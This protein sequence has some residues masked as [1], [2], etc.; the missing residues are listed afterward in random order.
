MFWMVR[1]RLPL[2]AMKT[3]I[4]SNLR[5][6]EQ[7]GVVSKSDGYQALINS[8]VQV[9]LLCAQIHLSSLR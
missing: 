3:K 4:V 8:I 7:L 6:L 9:S 5:Q 2:E 1:Y